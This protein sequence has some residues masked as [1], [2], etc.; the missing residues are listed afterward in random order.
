VEPK[1]QITQF[2]IHLDLTLK[3]YTFHYTFDLHGV[4]PKNQTQFL[5]HLN[6]TL[7][8]YTFLY[9]FDLHGVEPKNQITQ[10]LIH[11]NLTLKLYTYYLYGPVIYLVRNSS[12]R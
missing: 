9:T 1:N 10:F 2:L 6:L 4:E 12:S 7:K 8:L 3:L 11:L 5:I